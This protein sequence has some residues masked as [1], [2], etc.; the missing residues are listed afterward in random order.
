MFD[1]KQYIKSKGLK[2]IEFSEKI[3]IDK[4][5]LSKIIRGLNPITDNVIDKINAVY[6]DLNKSEILKLTTNNYNSNVKKL[7]KQEVIQVDSENFMEVAVLSINAQAGYLSSI[8]ENDNQYINELNTMLVPK[9]FEKGNYLVVEVN[10]D[11]MDDGTSRSL[12]HGDKLLCKQLQKHHWQGPLLIRKYLFV[13]VTNEGIVCKQITRQIETKLVCHS[14]N[15]LYEDYEVE[16]N[17]L[18]Q[19]FYVKKFVEKRIKF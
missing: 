16:M 6:N 11:S 10:G 8:F 12:C 3:G 9:E 4:D 2:Q 13:L 1:F 18:L 7:T 19:I 17:E 5:Y 14:F 15:E